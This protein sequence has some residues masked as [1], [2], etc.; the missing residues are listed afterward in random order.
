MDHAAPLTKTAKPARRPW[1][2]FLAALA[3][4]EHV[5][6]GAVRS[7]EDDTGHHGNGVA[8]E[9][10]ALE[11]GEHSERKIKGSYCFLLFVIF[12]CCYCCCCCFVIA[13]VAS[14]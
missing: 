12:C 10:L 7:K 3:K 9:G 8:T 4:G 13:V 6:V 5:P 1:T 2:P 11:H 14:W